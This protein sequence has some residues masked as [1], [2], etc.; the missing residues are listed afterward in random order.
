MAITRLALEE[1]VAET[2]AIAFAGDAPVALFCQ[3]P[4]LGPR[5]HI[6]DVLRARLRARDETGGAFLEAE[7]GESLF[8]KSAPRGDISLGAELAVQ[9]IAEAR[10]GKQARV[11]LWREADTP[12]PAPLEFW[13]ASL[14]GARALNW[15]TALRADMDATFEEALSP[16]VTLPGGGTLSLARTPALTAIDID[17]AGRTSRGNPAERALAINLVAAREAA[18]QVSLRGLGGLIILDCL[19]PIPR[20]MGKAVKTAFLESFREVSCRKAEALAPSPFGLM[21]TA[22]AWGPTPLDELLLAGDG[23]PAP[24]AV[25]LEGLRR[26]Q[27]EAAARPA[28]PLMLTL[29]AVAFQSLEADLPGLRTA[30]AARYGARLDIRPGARN[31]IEVHIP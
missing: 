14:P 17:T 6:G 26:L 2:R 4:L 10:R 20:D 19:G 21:E 1:T 25:A 7:T 8:L 15:E 29:P 11:R 16:S 12:S 9:I 3:S 24:Q 5:L 27:R 22:L 13:R 28:D 18:R 23:A 31:Q 30:L